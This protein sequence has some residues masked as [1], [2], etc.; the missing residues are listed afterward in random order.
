MSSL[1]PSQ[2]VSIV[3]DDE[4]VRLATANLLRSFGV[5]SRTFI[6]VEAF[7][8]S[9]CVDHTA[10]VISDMQMPGMSGIDLQTALR[11]RQLRIPMVFITAFPDHAL[12]SIAEANGATCFLTKPVDGETILACIDHAINRKAC[13][14][15]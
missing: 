8:A 1:L 2:V 11:E 12:R 14:G 3:D 10:C 13:G 15:H 7:L 6:S 9:E 5:Q 4:S